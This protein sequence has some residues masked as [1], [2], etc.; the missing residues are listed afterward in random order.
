MRDED[1]DCLSTFILPPSSLLSQWDADG[2]HYFEEHGLG[3]FAAAHRRGITGADR[4]PVRK[5]RNYE[6]FDVV[7]QAVAS[8]FSQGQCLGSTKE[9]ECAAWTD[10]QIQ[11]FR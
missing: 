8:F 1:S 11:H 2:F 4:K 10:S 9:R 3:F 6:S 5:D 7:R